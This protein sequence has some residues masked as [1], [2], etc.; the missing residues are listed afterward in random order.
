[1]FCGL[2]PTI[3]LFL[4]SDCLLLDV[5]P[6]LSLALAYGR[7][8]LSTVSAHLQKTTKTAS[9]STFVSCHSLINWLFFCVVAACYLGNLKNSLIGPTADIHYF[10]PTILWLLDVWQRCVVHCTVCSEWGWRWNCCWSCVSLWLSLLC[11]L[12]R[13][14]TL[15]T[16]SDAHV[17]HHGSYVMVPSE[18]IRYSE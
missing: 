3:Y 4:L 14:I 9:V 11:S 12:Q 10:E 15:T 17:V 18:T 6:S 13:V 16:P 2:H 1:M 7:C 8:H 5:A